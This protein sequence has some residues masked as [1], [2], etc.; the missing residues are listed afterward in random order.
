MVSTLFTISGIVTSKCS[1]LSHHVTLNVTR[2]SQ[3][4]RVN[5]INST[6]IYVTSTR[7][8]VESDFH[9]L[10]SIFVYTRI[11]VLMIMY[12]YC[13]FDRCYTIGP[14]LPCCQFHRPIMIQWHPPF[15]INCFR[16]ICSTDTG[17][18]I[19]QPRI[20]STDQV[21]TDCTSMRFEG[22]QGSMAGLEWETTKIVRENERERVQWER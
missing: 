1:G 2:G 19:C 4:L 7:V 20:L 21:E 14:F 12:K 18:W 3:R 6:I 17:C 10:H 16:L 8:W 15:C 11:L 5:H 13:R 22:W 9:V